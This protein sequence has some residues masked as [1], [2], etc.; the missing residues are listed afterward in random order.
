MVLY[1]AQKTFR[2]WL[3]IEDFHLKKK[4]ISL[5]FCVVAEGVL[6]QHGNSRGRTAFCG[7]GCSPVTSRVWFFPPVCLSSAAPHAALL[8]AELSNPCQNI[9]KTWIVIILESL[10]LSPVPLLCCISLSPREVVIKSTPQCCF[11]RSCAFWFKDSL[12]FPFKSGFL[13]QIHLVGM[14][15]RGLERRKSPQMSSQEMTSASDLM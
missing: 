3:F 8:W 14:K 15:D 10:N 6:V 1:K 5:S 4:L 2:W 12:G 9:S 7:S 11:P 13:L